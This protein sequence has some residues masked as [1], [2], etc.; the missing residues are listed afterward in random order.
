ML[1]LRTSLTGAWVNTVPGLTVV[2]A[3]LRPESTQRS[4]AVKG[5]WVAR[6]SCSEIE[7]SDSSTPLSLA[8]LTSYPLTVRLESVAHWLP[9]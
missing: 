9:V 4:V 5:S 1:A 6:S 8:P 2:I 3:H 7:S